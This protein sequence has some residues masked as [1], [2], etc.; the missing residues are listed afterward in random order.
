MRYII[1]VFISLYLVG[2]EANKSEPTTQQTK[3]SERTIL[4]PKGEKVILPQRSEGHQLISRVA[5]FIDPTDFESDLNCRDMFVYRLSGKQEFSKQERGIFLTGKLV[6]NSIV[7]SYQVNGVPENFSPSGFTILT[8]NGPGLTDELQ[9]A[10]KAES[11]VCEARVIQAIRDYKNNGEL[12][13][14][15]ST[16][17]AQ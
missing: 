9:E 6:F 7:N 1:F 5:S 13:K 12:G 4:G 10:M 11:E 16:R 2:C 3:T 17:G 14:Y 8:G 15:E